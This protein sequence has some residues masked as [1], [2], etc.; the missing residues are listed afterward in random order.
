MNFLDSLPAMNLDGIKPM[1]PAALVPDKDKPRQLGE[2][3]KTIRRRDRAVMLDARRLQ[4]AIEHIGRLPAENESFHLITEKRYSMMHIIPATL[5]LG[6]PAT[7]AYLGI[8]TLS[9]SQANLQDLLTLLDAGQIEKVDFAY[10]CYFKS[11]NKAD[12]QRLAEEL[13][14]RGH[15]VYSGLIHAKILLIELTDG[16]AY[17]VESSANLCSCASVENITMIHDRELFAFH[18]GWICELMENRK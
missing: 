2:D 11:N 5:H 10:S 12:C 1:F 4:N 16:R 9:F 7:I 3:R 14:A 15:R 13:T 18:S 6:E 17:S 8:V